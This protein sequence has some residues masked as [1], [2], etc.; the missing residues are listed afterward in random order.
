MTRSRKLL[1]ALTL[2]IPIAAGGFILQTRQPAAQQG[3][4]LLG[5][6]IRIISDRYVDTVSQSSVYE[7]AALGLVKELNDPYS[8]L[9][10]PKDVKQFNSR[11]GG[12]YAGLGMLIEDQQGSITV[13]KV[14]PNTP[15]ERGGVREGDRIVQV[16]TLSTR[17]WTLG[18]VSDY[19]V[20]TEGTPVQVRFGRPGIG[21]PITLDFKRAL[22]HVP[23]VP[24]AITFDNS[25]GYVPLEAFNENA[26]EEALAAI[27]KLSAAGAKGII[28]DLRRNPGG[29]LTQ[30]ISI[31][32]LFLKQGQ[33]VASVRSRSGEA[34]SYVTES[35]P[36]LPTTPLIVLVDEYSASAS[37][38]VTGAL[39]DHD[40]ALV[41]GQT[42]FGKGLVQSVYSLPGGY[43]LKLT[44]AKWFTPSG[45][46]IQR[47]RK[48]VNGQF[49]EE[50]PDTTETDASK[51]K[52]PAF[53][54]DLGRIVYGGGGVT[55]DLI[56]ADDT[57]STAEQ[58]FVKAI[59]PKSQV[60]YLTLYDYGLELSKSVPR[61]FTIKPEWR[62]E[63]FR[64][65][66]AKDAV[67]DRAL[68]DGARRYVD[69]NLEQRI[70]KFAFGDSTAKR[71]NLPYDSQLRR[72]L[73]LMR[74]AGSQ[75]QL[76]SLAGVGPA[77][78]P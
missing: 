76:F 11:T 61:D 19:L 68:F 14:Y 34:E 26:T 3:D 77:R 7:K 58:L 49:V 40:R 9:L 33:Q 6:V 38:I 28:F 47:E 64:R 13:S 10:T 21:S 29:I 72:A 66:N 32:N 36:A 22:I 8:E 60:F 67:V 44:T 63:F 78:Q 48:F 43:A 42:S 30:S 59:A 65:L 27:K 62:D 12:R 31:A 20:G 2:L 4:A 57:L 41:V 50:A 51:K 46:S 25:I 15:A 17:G 54:S 39:Q 45:R 53:K 37:E 18:Q 55:P 5:T 75:T 24:F 35:P 74:G 73:E 71:R 16:D 70:T 23:A 56:V 69:H 1:V 52:R